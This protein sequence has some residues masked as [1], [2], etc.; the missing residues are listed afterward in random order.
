[1]NAALSL[2]AL[3]ARGIELWAEGETL[4]YRAPAGTLT[5]DL[6]TAMKVHKPELLRTL[7]L[8]SIAAEACVSLSGYITASQLIAR[9]APEDLTD[10]ESMPKDSAVRFLRAFATACVWTDM[11][12]QGIAPPGWTHA[13]HCDRCGPVY[14]W[15][16]V[17][18]AG[19]PWCRNRRDGQK[20]PRPPVTPK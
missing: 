8:E 19:C 4:R 10:L 9:L 16:T 12:R 3:K 2:P 20:I 13:A 1:M 6:L 14:L 7:K 18:V 5:P 15:R 17:R 11:R